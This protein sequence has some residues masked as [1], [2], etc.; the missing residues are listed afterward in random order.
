MPSQSQNN[1]KLFARKNTLGVAVAMATV[2]QLIT[3]SPAAHAVLFNFDEQGIEASI[4]TTVSYGAMWRVQG[5]DSS[6]VQVENPGGGLAAG[7]MYQN[8]NDGNY[9]FDTGLVS[10]TYKV[11]TDF[12]ISKDNVGPFH[13]VG[14]FVRG[15]AFYDEVIMD[16]HN[17]SVPDNE[18]FNGGYDQNDWSNQAKNLAGNDARILDAYIFAD[19][20][21]GDMPANVR[22]GEQVISWGEGIFFQDGINTINPADASKLRLPGSEVREALTPEGALYFQIGL[23]DNLNME[24]FY[25]FEWHETEADG[26]GTFFSTS[27]VTGRGGERGITDVR[28]NDDLKRL[29][30]AAGVD[31]ANITVIQNGR[32]DEARLGGQW[33]VSFR[34]LAEE[35]NST[36]FG[37]YFVNYHSKKAVTNFA[38]G[39][40]F[41]CASVTGAAGTMPVWSATGDVTDTYSAYCATQLSLNSTL[42]TNVIGN[43]GVDNAT[44]FATAS[45]LAGQANVAAPTGATA[46][47]LLAWL[48]DT[49]AGGEVVL[50]NQTGLIFSNEAVYLETQQ[51]KLQYPEDIRM[52]GL[53]FNTQYGDTAL[54]GEVS[55]RPNTPLLTDALANSLG[56][57]L[58]GSL[59]GL[60]TGGGLGNGNSA[61]FG[62]VNPQTLSANSGFIESWDRKDVINGS[63][64]AISNHGAVLSLNDLTSILEVG[65]SHVGGLSSDDKYRASNGAVRA[66]L[67]PEDGS[68]TVA[69]ANTPYGE[70][71]DSYISRTSWGYRLAL[72]GRWDDAF[73]G[74]ALH[75]SINYAED[76]D[77]NS[78]AG[79]N[80][81]EGRKS[82]TLGLKA[83]YLNNTEASIAYTEFWDA[84]QSNQLRDRD[85]ISMNVKYSF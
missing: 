33:G 21:I 7:V 5:R 8:N 56:Q 58:V 75:P 40:D 47:Q 23:T 43:I 51:L 9:N 52:Y 1:K 37:L 60:S 70:V 25:Q 3:L 54:S 18:V 19:F 29:S 22:L 49:T 35:L 71:S 72:S 46:G 30:T 13:S 24:A 53:S 59:L 82:M 76:V 65:V 84:G 64:S 77:G 45:V 74:V 14:A 62:L 11:T 15:N 32:S 44:A 26:V 6:Y 48:N 38:T 4:D 80:F 50:A 39:D 55:F 27:D 28:G 61:V 31:P 17:D 79:G 16:K 63:F 42:A 57:G 36:E 20:D 85:N 41:G 68:L 10:S 34:Y 2:T 73:A 12:E 67:N 83:T 66:I 78:Y 69:T 81:I